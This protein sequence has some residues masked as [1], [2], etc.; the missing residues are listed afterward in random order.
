[1]E[2]GNGAVVPKQLQ[3]DVEVKKAYFPQE[4]KIQIH[5]SRVKPC[6]S[7][8]PSNY[9]W[10]ETRRKGAGHPPKD[11]SVSKNVSDPP[12][13]RDNLAHKL[14]GAG[15][16]LKQKCGNPAMSIARKKVKSSVK[17]RSAVKE[18]QTAWVELALERG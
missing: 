5:Q 15:H 8:F 10:Y 17:N 14:K 6:P 7:G 11:K 18:V 9:Y 12:P 4:G 13:K 16:P 3:K 1:M 2:T